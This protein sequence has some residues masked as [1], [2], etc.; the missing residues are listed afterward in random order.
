MPCTVL[1]AWG[2]HPAFQVSIK[3]Q[4]RPIAGLSVQFNQQA[5]AVSFFDRMKKISNEIK[6]LLLHE[7]TR[8]ERLLVFHDTH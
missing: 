3:K 4:S 7:V 8:D 6:N 1:E 5:V 2:P